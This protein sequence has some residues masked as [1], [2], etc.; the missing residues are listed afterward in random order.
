LNDD[1]LK[2]IAEAVV[3]TQVDGVIVT[4]TTIKRPDTLRSGNDIVSEIGGLS[5]PPLKPLALR[6][7][8]ALRRYTDGKVPL[9][10]CGGIE[11]GADAVE[12]AKAG[13]SF[14]QIYTAFGWDGVGV[15]RRIKEEVVEILRKEGKRWMDIVGEEAIEKA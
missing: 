12:F 3:A 4:N 7:L 9:I 5:G 10:G 2:Y 14:V 1:E 6:A 13:A 8:R 11:S 15:P